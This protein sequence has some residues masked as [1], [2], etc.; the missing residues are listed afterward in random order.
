[1]TATIREL[2]SPGDLGWVVM[3]NGEVYAREYG[4]DAT[5]EALVAGIVGAYATDHDPARERGW[6]AEVDGAR[7]GAVFCM[8]DDESTARLRL[9]LVDPRFRGH[10]VGAALVEQCVGFS[11]EAGY[12]RMV[13][14]TNSVLGSARRIY[15]AAGFGLTSERRHHSFGHDLVGQDWTLEPLV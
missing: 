11:R 6:I 4:W 2:G 1:M 8:A 5:Y 7:A 9:L 14:W 3:T 12:R 10:G 13:L 15:E